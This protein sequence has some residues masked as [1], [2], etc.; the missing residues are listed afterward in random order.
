MIGA[1]AAAAAG[2][3][4]PAP[5][6]WPLVAGGRFLSERESGQTESEPPWLSIFF[7]LL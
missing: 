1:A 6:G 7:D 3:R 5:I 2:R 4:A